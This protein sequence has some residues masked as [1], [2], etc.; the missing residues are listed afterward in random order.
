MKKKYTYPQVEVV[1]FASTN[2]TNA[3]IQQSSIVPGITGAEGGT[4]GA[5]KLRHVEI[6]KLNK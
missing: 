4:A 2:T 1:M 5:D 6:G 3:L